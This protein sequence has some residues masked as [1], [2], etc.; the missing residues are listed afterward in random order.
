MNDNRKIYL[1]ILLGICSLILIFHFLIL[2]KVIPYEI[3]WGGRLK[4]DTEMYTFETLSIAI[5]L[6]FV[7]V[8]L[9]KGAYVKAVFGERALSIILWVFFAIFAL[10][11]IGNLFAK[12]TFEKSF[13]LVTLVNAVSIW[14]INKKRSS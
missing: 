9:Q 12:T 11:T 1:K 7:Y 3:T 10:N 13:T 8:L 5:N 2:L 4:N 14:M 6:F